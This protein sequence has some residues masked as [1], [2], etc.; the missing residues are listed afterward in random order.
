MKRSCCTSQLLKSA[1]S[2]PSSKGDKKGTKKK[3][4]KKD[5]VLQLPLCC[6]SKKVERSDKEEAQLAKGNGSDSDDSLLMAIT[7][8]EMDKSKSVVH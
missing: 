3:I 7:N 4:D 1:G 8:T 2:E 5:V 6:H